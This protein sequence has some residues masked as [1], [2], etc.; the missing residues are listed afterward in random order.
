MKLIL[1]INN[2][3]C[4]L[5]NI[6]TIIEHTRYLYEIFNTFIINFYHY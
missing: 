6:N 3:K 1:A 4:E 5:T 2:N